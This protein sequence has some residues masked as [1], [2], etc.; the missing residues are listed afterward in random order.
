MIH[1]LKHNIIGYMTSS[2]IWHDGLA[3]FSIYG[4]YKCIYYSQQ[5]ML[6]FLNNGY[7]FYCSEVIFN[8]MP[9]LTYVTTNTLKMQH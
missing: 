2:T 4:Y 8:K 9:N 6:T 1:P 3:D 7:T 5:I